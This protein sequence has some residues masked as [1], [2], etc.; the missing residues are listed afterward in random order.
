MRKYLLNKYNNQKKA[1][2]KYFKLLQI[3][4]KIGP[5]KNDLLETVQSR[6][7]LDSSKVSHVLAEIYYNLQ[8]NTSIQPP[9][10]NGQLML[11][12]GHMFCS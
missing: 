3:V 10:N 12:T 4:D 6:E 8:N 9:Q 5:L 11:T 1:L 7:N 2:E